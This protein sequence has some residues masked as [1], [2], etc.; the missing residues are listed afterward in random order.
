MA[1]DARETDRDGGRGGAAAE[2]DGDG[3]EA[4]LVRVLAP[5]LQRQRRPLLELGHDR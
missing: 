4:V 1:A 3:G 2:T 5:T